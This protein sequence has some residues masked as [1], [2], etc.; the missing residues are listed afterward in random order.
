MSNASPHET[1]T[2]SYDELLQKNSRLTQQCELYKFELEQLKQHL[3]GKRSE[4]LRHVFPGQGNLFTQ[5]IA[6]P[7]SAEEDFN[8]VAAHRRK[9][10]SKKSIPHDLPVETTVFYPEET[11]CSTCGEEL[12]EFS[13][14]VREELDFIPAR[15]LK[16]Q[17]VTV[18][19]SCAKCSATVSGRVPA[20]NKPVI[21]G[22]Q[23]G[24]GL[25]AHI[26]TSK[27]CDHLPYYRQS[28]I[29]EREGVFIPDKTLSRYGLAI[30][31][32]LE[33]VAKAIKEEIFKTEYIQADETRLHVLDHERASNIHKG[34]Y[35]WGIASPLCSLVY[36]EYHDSRSQTAADKCLG[37]YEQ[38]C[39]TDAYVCYDKHTGLRIGCMAHARR[40]FVEAQKLAPK[41]SAYLLKLMAELYKIERTLKNEQKS[42]TSE[43]W[44]ERRMRYRQKHA[45]KILDKI[46]QYLLSIKDNWL[47]ENHPFYKAI[48]YMLNRFEQFVAYTADGRFEIDNNYIERAIR[49]IAVGRRNW[50]FAGSEH[51]ARMT[52]VM[53]TVLQSC[54]NLGINPQQYLAEVLP[55]LADVGTKSLDGLTPFNWNQ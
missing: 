48:N 31:E 3:F 42:L 7:E 1:S 47:L 18:H 28:Q 27:I 45:V 41:E 14:D 49:P 38:A 40:Y 54:K 39:Q 46:K 35:L 8:D 44:Y 10:R 51:G 6:V 22:A 36:F 11:H 15:F 26:A 4:K 43:Q 2:P 19:C 21:P 17:Y 37:A 53:I 55:R 52:A 32:L 24:A 9:R 12:K 23:I 5:E 29:F 30:G 16:K 20:A 13:R 50:L 25:L 34:G 33:P